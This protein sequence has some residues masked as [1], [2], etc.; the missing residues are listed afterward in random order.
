MFLCVFCEFKKI[1]KSSVYLCVLLAVVG[2]FLF[3][4]VGLKKGMEFS[5]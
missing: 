4:F 3:Y 2:G 1:K 5:V